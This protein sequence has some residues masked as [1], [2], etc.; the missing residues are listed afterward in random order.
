MS[1]SAL[2]RVVE[3]VGVGVDGSCSRSGGLSVW[4]SITRMA[5]GRRRAIAFAR[6]CVAK[7]FDRGAVDGCGTAAACFARRS[8]TGRVDDACD[9]CVAAMGMVWAY[10]TPAKRLWKQQKGR[11]SAAVGVQGL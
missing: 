8:G 2:L 3:V 4:S 10:G 5:A 1:T 9:S 11:R 6:S 7:E